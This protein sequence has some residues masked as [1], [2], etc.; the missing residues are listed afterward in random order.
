LPRREL[1]KLR[2]HV[3]RQ[4]LDCGDTFVLSIKLGSCQTPPH[5]RGRR[6]RNTLAGKTDNTCK[7]I[8]TFAA[9]TESVGQGTLPAPC[10]AYGI[11]PQSACNST[12][13]GR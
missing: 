9:A 3:G 2:L 10:V 11:E 7:G 1:C 4:T 12:L 5:G 8:K 13:S 6:S